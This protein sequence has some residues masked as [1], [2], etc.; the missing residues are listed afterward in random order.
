[1]QLSTVI[2]SFFQPKVPAGFGAEDG[3]SRLLKIENIFPSGEM[4]ISGM[5]VKVG[6]QY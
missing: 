6:M 2:N 1:M 5:G 3:A 4:E